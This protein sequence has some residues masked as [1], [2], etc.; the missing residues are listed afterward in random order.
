MKHANTIEQSSH[1]MIL[2]EVQRNL[3]NFLDNL[4]NIIDLENTTDLHEIVLSIRDIFNSLFYLIQEQ[5]KKSIK[6]AE[7]I[8]KLTQDVETLKMSEAELVLG[9][10][11]TQLIIKCSHYLKINEPIHITKFRT[12]SMLNTNEN[13]ALL[14]DFLNRNGDDW[15]SG[16]SRNF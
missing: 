8:D 5:D 13:I 10:M 16:V 12:S 3:N 7:N 15:N 14:K 6:L 11:A 4:W 1:G 2:N 9:S